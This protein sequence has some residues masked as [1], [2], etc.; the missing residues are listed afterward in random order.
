MYLMRRGKGA[1][2]RVVHLTPYDPITGNPTMEPLCG[3]S[4][5]IVFNMTSNVPWG[6]PCCKRCLAAARYPQRASGSED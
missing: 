2:R 6:Q 1:L 3:R 5:G 4:N